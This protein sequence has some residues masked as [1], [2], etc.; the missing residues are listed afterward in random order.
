MFGFWS[1]ADAETGKVATINND[2]VANITFSR[3]NSLAV[4]RRIPERLNTITT[5]TRHCLICIKASG[6]MRVGCWRV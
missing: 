3:M 2:K 4:L 6:A 5:C 1:S